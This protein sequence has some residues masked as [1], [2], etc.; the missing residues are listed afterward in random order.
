MFYKI[1]HFWDDSP[2]WVSIVNTRQLL[3][4]STLCQSEGF[5]YR[6]AVVN[7]YFICFLFLFGMYF[8]ATQA[9]GTSLLFPEVIMAECLRPARLMCFCDFHCS[10]MIPDPRKLLSGK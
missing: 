9:E 8:G 10:M 2:N 1:E 5:F 4:N 3:R 6:I 7:G